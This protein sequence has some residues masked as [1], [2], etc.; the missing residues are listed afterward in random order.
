MEV[1]IND[2][3]LGKSRGR[4]KKDASQAAAAVALRV[5]RFLD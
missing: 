3:I 4:T 5:L 2:Q 1:W